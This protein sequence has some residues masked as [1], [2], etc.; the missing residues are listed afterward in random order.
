MAGRVRKPI[1][2]RELLR[3]G[4]GAAAAL[5]LAGGAAAAE[6]VQEAK[7]AMSSQ[8]TSSAKPNIIF[9]LLDDVG[10]GDLACYGSEFYES[11]NI[12]RLAAEGTS[13][14]DAYAS[15][16]VCSPARDVMERLGAMVGG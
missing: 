16:P 10:W 7:D 1:T 9:I 8:S 11:R 14:T 2:R 15:C 13:F 3:R 5:G 12:D 6:P 4:V